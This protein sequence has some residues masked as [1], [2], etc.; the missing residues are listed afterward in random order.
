MLCLLGHLRFLLSSHINFEKIIISLFCLLWA[1]PLLTIFSS[2]QLLKKY[3]FLCFALLGISTFYYLLLTSVLKK[4]I[5][6]L[7]YLFG[8]LRF[9]LSSSHIN[10]LKII[11]SLL[12]LLGHLRFLLSS[13]H[14]NF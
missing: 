12:C 14:I 13:S 6:S 3:K 11:I 5:I 4:Y 10:L 1:S 8:H 9:L 2:H 7:F